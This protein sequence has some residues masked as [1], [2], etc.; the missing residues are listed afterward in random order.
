MQPRAASIAI[1][2]A[3]RVVVMRL[4]SKPA[5]HKPNG[6]EQQQDKGGDADQKLCHLRG[7]FQSGP[8]RQVAPD[9]RPLQLLVT[10]S[11]SFD[12]GIN[13]P[14]LRAVLESICSMQNRHICRQTLKFSH[15]RRNAAVSLIPARREINHDE[16][17]REQNRCSEF[18]KNCHQKKASIAT[19]AR[20]LG[21]LRGSLAPSPWEPSH[22]WSRQATQS[23]WGLRRLC[24]FIP[25]SN[26]G[27]LRLERVQPC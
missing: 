18:F 12:I 7:S 26:L 21:F 6:C 2:T 27:A 15:F 10:L 13:L 14:G 3:A 20:S 23:T 11:H 24:R 8:G 19:V 4:V 16:H 22:R 9:A 25:T 5:K 1:V 17:S